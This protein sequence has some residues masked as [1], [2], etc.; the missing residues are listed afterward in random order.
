MFI[1]VKSNI[2]TAS[3]ATR[4]LGEAMTVALRGGAVSGFLVVALSLLG[5]SVLFLL[6]GGFSSAV[7]FSPK[8]PMSART[9]WARLRQIFL[10]M[11][12]AIPR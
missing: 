1:A 6:Y 10:K 11:I 12:H 9:W 2:R 5:V 7:A 3:A 8:L 4:S